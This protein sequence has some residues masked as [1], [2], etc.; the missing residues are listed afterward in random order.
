LVGTFSLKYM[1]YKNNNSGKWFKYVD[2]AI[3]IDITFAVTKILTNN[4][5]I[6]TPQWFDLVKHALDKGALGLIEKHLLINSKVKQHPSFKE[7][8]HLCKTIKQRN[9]IYM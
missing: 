7:L 3:D 6:N 8:Q 9:E 4:A 1:T 2:Q 5:I